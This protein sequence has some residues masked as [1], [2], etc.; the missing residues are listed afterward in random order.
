MRMSSVTSKKKYDSLVFSSAGIFT[1]PV[2][3]VNKI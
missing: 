3:V 2:D 1:Y